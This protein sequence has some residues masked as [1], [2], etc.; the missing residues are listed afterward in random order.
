AEHPATFGYYLRDE[1]HAVLFPGL[2]KVSASIRKLAPTKIPFINLFPNYSTP[3]QL[4]SKTY[5]EHLEQFI[6]TCNPAMVGYDHYA[7]MDD[8][9]LRDGYY[10]N[11]ES[12]RRVTLKHNLPFWNCVLAVG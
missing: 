2:A 10:Q 6:K 7:L 8:G 11:L 9:S 3:D 5:D 4:G 12:V 1:P